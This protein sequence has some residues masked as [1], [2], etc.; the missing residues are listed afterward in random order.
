M[1]GN[2]YSA[3]L[4]TGISSVRNKWIREEGKETKKKKNKQNMKK[5]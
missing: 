3:G 5:D 1:I 2:F 4:I